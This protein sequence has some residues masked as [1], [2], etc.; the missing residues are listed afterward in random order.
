MAIDTYTNLRAEIADWLN[1]QDLTNQIP[2][3][4]RLLETQV[5]RSLRVRH[6]VTRSTIQVSS[7]FTNLPADYLSL[8]N[9]QLDT[10]PVTQLEYVPMGHL[11]DVRRQYPSASKPM[12]YSIVGTQIEVAPVPDATYDMEIVYYAKIPKLAT[13]TQETNWLLDN[14]GDL[15]LYGALMNAAPYLED[16]QRVGLWSTALNAILEDIR[17]ADERSRAAGQPLKMRIKPYGPK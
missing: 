6:M 7:Q 5:E 3:F 15:Y 11:D 17:L 1:R 8:V 13:G 10:D 9:V 12:F 16:D 2:T 4:I 14:Y